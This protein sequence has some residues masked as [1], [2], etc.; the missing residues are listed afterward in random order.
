MRVF[1]DPDQ[2]SPSLSPTLEPVDTITSQTEANTKALCRL[3]KVQSPT[4]SNQYVFGISKEGRVFLHIPKSQTGTT[5]EKGKSVD[6][7]VLGLIKAIIGADDT[8]TSLDIRTQGGVKLD[9]GG[10]L[11][12][13]DPENPALTSVELNLKG[14]IRTIYSGEQGRES[15]IGGSDLRSVTASSMDSIGGSCVRNVGGADA[16]EAF[17][18]TQNAG[19][20]GLKQKC[21]G[22]YN[23]TVLGKT[24][25]LYA[26]PRLS[27]FALADTKTMLAGLDTTVVLA[28]GITRNVVAGTGITDS[29]AAGNFV[30]SAGVGNM[31]MNVGTGN[32]AASVAAGNL[33]LS[34]GAGN[35]SMAAGVT[36]TMAAGSVAAI[37]SPI[38]KIGLTAVGFA[39]AGIPGPLSP[40]LDYVTG[41]P[42]LG[43][44]TVSLG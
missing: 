5:Q 2:G 20:G 42:L 17:S 8:R 39:V 37:A 30:M 14:K 36:A 25:E 1:D 18:I 29:V 3:F 4:S 11:D 12:D 15:F 9:L 34:A 40:H 7:N 23:N 41:L 27:T 38:T 21:A 6:A 26:Q 31:L 10:F 28:G 33:A 32:L 16:T 35:V 22:D 44:P 19:F 13:T 43:I 24:T